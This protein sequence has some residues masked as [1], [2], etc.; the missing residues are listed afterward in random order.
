MGRRKGRPHLTQALA[1]PSLSPRSCSPSAPPT[2]VS[3]HVAQVTCSPLTHAHSHMH[4]HICTLTQH[5]HTCTSHMHPH[6]APSH[7]HPHTCT[8]THAP[9]HPR[10]CTFTHAAPSHMH[11]HTC[12]P[13]PPYGMLVSCLS[14]HSVH[15][16]IRHHVTTLSNKGVGGVAVI[17][18]PLLRC[19]DEGLRGDTEGSTRR[20]DARIW[21]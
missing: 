20:P 3:I 14:V 11:P 17:N 1:V 10:T 18:R 5:T 12:T 6:T 2:T 21:I 4:L 19:R 16:Y 13:L 15:V 7:M 8:L 9:S